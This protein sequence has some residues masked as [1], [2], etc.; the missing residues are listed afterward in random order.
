MILEMIEMLIQEYLKPIIMI[1]GLIEFTKPILKDGIR[2]SQIMQI[3]FCV[4]AV[5]LVTF[6]GEISTPLVII[7]TIAYESVFMISITTLFYDLFVKRIKS[8]GGKVA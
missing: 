7:F 8:I 4:L 5:I 1:V 3:C 6:Q 2:R